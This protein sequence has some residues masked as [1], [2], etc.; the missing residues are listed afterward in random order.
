MKINRRIVGAVMV[1]GLT[2]AACGSDDDSSD[3]EVPSTDAPASEPSDDTNEESASTEDT[4]EES[5]ST[6]DTVPPAQ[7]LEVVKL[8]QVLPFESVL[9]GLTVP[10]GFG[11][12]V[13]IAH[14]NA[15]GAI[16]GLYEFEL[17]RKD[18][19]LDEARMNTVMRELADEGVNLT[20]GFQ[21]TSECRSAAAAAS[22]DQIVLASH[23]ASATLTDPAIVPNFWRLNATDVTLTKAMG[24]TLA[25]KYPEI[26]HWDVVG[27]DYETG[28]ALWTNTQSAI[29][30]SLGTEVLTDQEFWIPIGE[31]SFADV[32][33][34]QSRGLTGDKATRGLFLSTYGGGTTAYLQQAEPL[35]LTNEYAVI[36][37][38][39]A[40]W[41]TAIALGERAP[42]I[43]NAYEY[44][45]SCQSNE[46]NDRFV[47]D[48]EALAGTKPDTG[49]YQAYTSVMWYKAA[50]EKA[51]SIDP[52]A[53]QAAFAGMELETLVGGTIDMNGETHQATQPLTIAPLFGDAD[54]PDQ[55]GIESCAITHSRD[56]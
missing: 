50:I 1:L 32:V 11:A 25:A 37:Q 42:L 52:A 22:E 24:E 7:D 54:S 34:A 28:R 10:E 51:G 21:I 29:A 20:F 5:A 44:F 35:G 38:N 9:A 12:E 47:A 27:Y 16:A 26:E 6:E 18:D 56:L 36:A 2:M 13:G 23:C 8:G 45:W 3:A 15:D 17:V 33:A 30:E 43:E 31:Q 40:Y 49:A 14:A 19:Q 39:G 55:V 4:N 53:V 46:A 41:E 48:Y